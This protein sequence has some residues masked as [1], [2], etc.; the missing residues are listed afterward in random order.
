[1]QFP[2]INVIDD[3][4]MELEKGERELSTNKSDHALIRVEFK[5]FIIYSW[6][7]LNG[8]D[9]PAL[10]MTIQ[11]FTQYKNKIQLLIDYF[12]NNNSTRIRNIGIYLK[13]IR[14]HKPIIFMFQEL[15][16]ESA[17]ILI[18]VICDLASSIN[19]NIG[20]VYRSKDYTICFSNQD[21]ITFSDNEQH[22]NEIRVT[23]IPNKISLKSFHSIQSFNINKDY[24]TKK[25]FK[26]QLFTEITYLDKT[27]SLVNLHL[28]FMSSLDNFCDFLEKVKNY[29]NLIIIGDFNNNI[30][31]R[32]KDKIINRFPTFR[33]KHKQPEKDT[34]IVPMPSYV[35]KEFQSK[36][37][38]QVLYN[39]EDNEL[40]ED[41]I[42]DDYKFNKKYFYLYLKYK[43]KY[44]QIK[45]I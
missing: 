39:L 13:L 1:M 9:K 36:I 10:K 41:E 24:P 34:F 28:N 31:K 12:Y 30:K 44:L 45:N 23:I 14:E 26:S 16:L 15:S 8:D 29:N 7:L 2:I 33:F 27:Y 5:N 38:D 17:N 40:I 19:I 42:L 3:T 43:N 11:N 4:I 22:K 32:L 25:G 21:Q 35:D 20:E 6:N 37:L 18:Q